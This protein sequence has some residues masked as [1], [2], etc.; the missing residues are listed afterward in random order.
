MTSLIGKRIIQNKFIVEKE[1][2]HP[3]LGKDDTETIIIVCC[4]IYIL[5]MFLLFVRIALSAEL[6]ELTVVVSFFPSLLNP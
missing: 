1:I 6:V 5:A 4:L 2:F 3:L